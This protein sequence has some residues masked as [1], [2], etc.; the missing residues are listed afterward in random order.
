M[1]KISPVLVEAYELLRTDI[2]GYLDETEHLTEFAVWTEKEKGLL[3]RVVPDLTTVIRG[4]V[5]EHES[6][7]SGACRKCDV[8]WP[9]PVTESIHRLI[10]DPTHVF[11][12]ILIHVR[13]Q[14]RS[15]LY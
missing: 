2:Y 9:C 8:P 15:R 4:M 7:T 10:K 12:Q 14:D 3:R 1:D 11:R 5:V 6:S 13:E